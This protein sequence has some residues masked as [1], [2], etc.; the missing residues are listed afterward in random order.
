MHEVYD[1]WFM[2]H[3][4]FMMQKNETDSLCK[5]AETELGQAQPKLRLRVRLNDL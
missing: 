1:V 2:I 5:Q 3:K 4:A